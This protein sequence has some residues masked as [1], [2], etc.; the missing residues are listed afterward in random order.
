[1]AAQ[2]AVSNV[3]IPAYQLLQSLITALALFKRHI[4]A[5]DAMELSR[6]EEEFQIDRWGLVEGGHDLDRVNCRV[7]VSSASFLLWLLQ[8][9]H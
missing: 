4:T 7:R 6:V 5:S 2:N 8:N 9:K 3:V 1:L